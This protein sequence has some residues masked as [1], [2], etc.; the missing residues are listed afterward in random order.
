[1]PALG[2]KP[3]APSCERNQAP[4]LA[5]LQRHFGGVRRVLEVASGTGQHAAHCSAGLPGW[6]WLPSDFEADAGPSIRA[7]CEGLHSVH[8][9]VQLDVLSTPWPMP[10]A[11]SSTVALPLATTW[12]SARPSTRK[13]CARAERRATG[14]APNSARPLISRRPSPPLDPSCTPW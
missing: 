14:A 13:R 5:V 1:M 7:W 3:F 10:K 4:I 12:R 11:R 2:E 9:P 6:R 8:P